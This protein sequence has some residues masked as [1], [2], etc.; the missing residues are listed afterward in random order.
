MTTTISPPE[1]TR[2]VTE[3]LQRA[4]ALSDKPFQSKLANLVAAGLVSV[5]DAG[6]VRFRHDLLRDAAYETQRRSTRRSRH[7]RIA[8]LLRDG[9]SVRSPDACR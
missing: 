5:S 3:L 9:P 7:S 8:D 2:S 6:V 1:A 4:C